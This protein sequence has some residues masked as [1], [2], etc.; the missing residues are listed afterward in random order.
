MRLSRAREPQVIDRLRLDAG[1][2]VMIVHDL[3][4]GSSGGEGVLE[5]TIMAAAPLFLVA[6]DLAGL[7]GSV[8]AACS[9]WRREGFSLGTCA[10][11]GL[12]LFSGYGAEGCREGILCRSM[13][14]SCD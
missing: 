4:E 11:I 2:K 1:S 9:W 3:A 7:H 8:R 14:V 6:S 12:R 5:V 10:L 13:G